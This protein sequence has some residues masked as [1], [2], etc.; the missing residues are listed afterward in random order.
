MVKLNEDQFCKGFFNFRRCANGPVESAQR[1]SYES[2]AKLYDVIDLPEGLV[3]EVNGR[4]QA[5]CK[6]H[7]AI[8]DHFQ[9]GGRK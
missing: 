6:I 1:Y 4:L 2:G 8:L 9:V 7:E 3:F 5:K